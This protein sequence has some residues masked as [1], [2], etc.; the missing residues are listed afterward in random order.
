MFARENGYSHY[1]VSAKTGDGIETPFEDLVWLIFKS[2]LVAGALHAP[3]AGVG[4]EKDRSGIPR[5]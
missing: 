5:K 3:T 2:D 1:T 4:Q